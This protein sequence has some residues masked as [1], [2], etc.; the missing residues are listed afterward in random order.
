MPDS[1]GQQFPIRTTEV[2]LNRQ[3]DERSVKSEQ[4]GSATV[5]V[6]KEDV[7]QI[8]H[9]RKKE[10]IK[11]DTRLI[12]TWIWWF[13]LVGGLISALLYWLTRRKK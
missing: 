4:S 8:E 7:A 6:K 2:D 13:L 5:Q 1:V 11:T 3:K 12:P 9:E 10:N